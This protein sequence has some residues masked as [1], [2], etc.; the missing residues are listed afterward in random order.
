MWRAVLCIVTRALSH[1]KLFATPWAVLCQAP[2]S[3]E[4]SKQE[5][6][7][8]LPFPPPGDLPNLEADS[9]PLSHLGSPVQYK[10]LSSSPD[11]Y[12]LDASS[13]LPVVTTKNVSRHCQMSP[14]GQKSPLIE[15]HWWNPKSLQM[16][17]AAMKLKVA[18][19]L[20][21]KLWP[22]GVFCISIQIVKLYVLVLW[23]IPLV[24]WPWGMGWGGRWEGGPGW[25][26]HV[27]PWLIHVNVWQKPLQYCKVISLQLK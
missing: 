5:H 10:I 19:S 12:L 14:G 22:F 15:S 27:H 26:T 25:G 11:F 9:L 7:S 20:Q 24:A 23:K 17:T 4:F 2:L 21:E 8:G 1:V 16:V 6:G 3:M 13:T 18:Y